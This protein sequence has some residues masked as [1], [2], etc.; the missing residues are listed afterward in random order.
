MFDPL[1]P[2][3]IPIQLL[4]SCSRPQGTELLEHLQDVNVNVTGEQQTLQSVDV[5]KHQAMMQ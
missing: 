5:L 2:M 4:Q 3:M 1:F